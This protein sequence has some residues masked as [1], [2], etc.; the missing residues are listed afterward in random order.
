[1]ERE[2]S[3]LEYK[4]TVT[5]TFLKTVSAYANYGT[6]RIVFGV[7]DDGRI[8]GLANPVDD[9]LRIENMINDTVDPVPRYSMTIDDDA[10]TVSL[11]VYEGLDKPYLCGGRAYRRQDASTREA[12][13]LELRRLALEGQGKSFDALVARVQ[14]FSFS[15]LAR[16]LEKS[17][18]ITSLDDG[19]MRTLGLKTPDGQFTNAAALLA[20][21]N[22]FPGIDIAVFGSSA[23]QFR[24]R[25]T[26]EG[27]SLVSQYR[28]ALDEHER[29]CVS[30]V[31]EG[32]SRLRKEDVPTEA[33][34]EAVANA[35]VHRSWD[36]RSD[37]TVSI[38]P[39]HVDVV[40][41]GGLPEG[42]S[43]EDYL[44]G[45]VSSPRNPLVANVFFRLDIIERF[46]TGIRRIHS[47]Y[48]GT[49]MS[50]S[51]DVR[52]NSVAVSLPN[53]SA[54]P[55]LTQDEVKVLGSLG[56]S[57]LLAR[58]AIEQKTGFSKEKTVR[59]LRNLEARGLVMR[60]GEGRGAR[61]R[62]A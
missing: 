11:T 51:F 18:G 17:L 19:V 6:G 45:G 32:A 28:A 25:Q 37:V 15:V 13:H 42:M 8:A 5:K 62:L 52:P 49:G 55:T 57:V 7:R 31:V 43:K 39:D 34:R 20:D 21:E 22:D 9:A 54:M 1:M 56:R 40:S 60:D 41:P 58:D 3:T 48:E 35:L 61:Y 59:L 36:L 30:E 27:A 23:N 12:G 24:D 44:R 14:E 2:S 26:I 47:A 29:Y 50:P 33:F 46:G 16:G 53:V 4:E 10:A 38:F